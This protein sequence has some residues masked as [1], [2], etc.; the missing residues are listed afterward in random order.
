MH[1]GI[2]ATR[3]EPL[4]EPF[5]SLELDSKRYAASTELCNVCLSDTEGT[6]RMSI[7]RSGDTSI[8]S[9]RRASV[10]RQDR[11]ISITND[12]AEEAKAATFKTLLNRMKVAKADIYLSDCEGHDV[13]LIEQ[14]P[15]EQLGVKVT[16][17]ELW[18]NPQAPEITGN[19]LV[20][21]STV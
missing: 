1:K 17:L 13:E 11:R 15:I 9:T 21:V 8:Y 5:K 16:Y 2:H 18:D 20:R 10:I 6:L 14:L 4:S 12:G 19:A 3:V 7:P